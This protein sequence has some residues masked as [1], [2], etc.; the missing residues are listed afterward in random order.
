M[1]S[2][3]T[4]KRRKLAP[5]PTRRRLQPDD[6]RSELLEAAIEVLRKLGPQ[7]ARVE[8]VVREA[9]AAKGTFYL[10]FPSWD[11]L[12]VAV[13]DHLI[14]DYAA[15]VQSRLAAGRAMS[16]E[17]IES[18]CAR[19]V[20]YVVGLGDLHEAIFHNPSATLPEVKGSSAE[21][22]I[23]EMLT[24]GAATGSCR[25]VAAGMAAPLLFSVL[26]ATADGIARTGE[27]EERIEVLLQLLRAWLRPGPG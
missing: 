13:R 8:D 14:S 12:L 7:H 25:A 19:F 18:E 11:D 27:R 22:I 21:A 20:D 10:Y 3:E 2:V 1:T 6:R 5:R 15:E 16:W 26:H 9:G 23:S 17:T 4:K 24:M